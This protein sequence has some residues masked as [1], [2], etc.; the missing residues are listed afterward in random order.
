MYDTSKLSQPEQTSESGK[1]ITQIVNLDKTNVLCV[2]LFIVGLSLLG[3][4]TLIDHVTPAPVSPLVTEYLD[5]NVPTV[6]GFTSLYHVRQMELR[7][8]LAHKTRTLAMIRKIE[9]EDIR[10]SFAEAYN[11]A[12]K[13][14]G[15]TIQDIVVGSEGNP[16]SVAGMLTMAAPGLMA[17][18]AM[19]RKQDYSPE[20]AKKLAKEVEKRTEE[21]IRKEISLERQR[22]AAA[23]TKEA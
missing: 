19:K 23:Q 17:G 21:R 2:L 11:D 15:Q 5:V 10:H 20:G 9:D 6:W 12:A 1:K 22:L 18:R 7:I 4:N 8:D 14:E 3:C 13:V 16:F